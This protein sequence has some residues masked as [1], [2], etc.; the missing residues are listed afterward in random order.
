MAKTDSG[1]DTNK[2][3]QILQDVNTKLYIGTEV[4]IYQ[5]KSPANWLWLS[6]L[7]GEKYG[8]SATFVLVCFQDG[9]IVYTDWA[10]EKDD[11]EQGENHNI[12]DWCTFIQWQ[13]W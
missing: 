10:Q 13:Y 3:L 11:S 7:N 5:R 12:M 9:E 6:S 1:Q 4:H 2:T 8:K